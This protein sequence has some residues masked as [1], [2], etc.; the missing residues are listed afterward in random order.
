[1]AFTS[2]L[3]CIDAEQCVDAASEPVDDVAII[4]VY[5]SRD[6]AFVRFGPSAD[7]NEP[8]SRDARLVEQAAECGV[9]IAGLEL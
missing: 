8:K 1:M 9:H 5:G 2:H 6:T 4:N 3:N 7:G